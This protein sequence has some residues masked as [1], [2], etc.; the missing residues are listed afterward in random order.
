MFELQFLNA[1]WPLLQNSNHNSD[2]CVD[3]KSFK[4]TRP[5]VYLMKVKAIRMGLELTDA[6]NLIGPLLWTQAMEFVKRELQSIEPNSSY[7]LLGKA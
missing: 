1:S 3:C 7:I 6:V 2:N 5:A 4:P